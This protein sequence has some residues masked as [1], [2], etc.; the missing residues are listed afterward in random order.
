VRFRPP[1]ALPSSR[2]RAPQRDPMANLSLFDEH[3]PQFA[4]AR[5]GAV[6]MQSQRLIRG[7]RGWMRFAA[8]ADVWCACLRYIDSIINNVK[9]LG[10][11]WCDITYSS[12]RTTSEPNSLRKTQSCPVQFLLRQVVLQPKTARLAHV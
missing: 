7:R 5:L 4:V 12:V 10:H 6:Q 2:A 9:W 11:E 8:D 3:H 1:P